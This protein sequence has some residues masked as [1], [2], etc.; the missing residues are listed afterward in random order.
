MICQQCSKRHPSILHIDKKGDPVHTQK[1]EDNTEEKS[2]SSAVVSL[3]KESCGCTGARE[4]EPI[5]AIVAVK[6]KSKRSEKTL[7]TYAF[8]DP[9]SSATFCTETLMKQLN[10][11]GKKTKILL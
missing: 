2:V 4:G 7:E 8:M 5:L 10:V 3:E 6:V 1:K 9:G 11:R